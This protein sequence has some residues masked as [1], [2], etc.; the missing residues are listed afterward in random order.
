MDKEF[1]LN[2]MLKIREEQLKAQTEI[3]VKLLKELD[4]AEEI[5]RRLSLCIEHL[6]EKIND[7]NGT[8][9]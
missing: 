7:L 4:Y 1:Y 5:N 2:R 6:E 3:N 8:K 9:N